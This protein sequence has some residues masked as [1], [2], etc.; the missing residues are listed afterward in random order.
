M[1]GEAKKLETPSH[2]GRRHYQAKEL[3]RSQMLDDSGLSGRTW[4]HVGNS[5]ATAA[6]TTPSREVGKRAQALSLPLVLQFAI[7]PP[8]WPP[9]K[10][11]NKGA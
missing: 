8:H 4:S 11:G 6:N 10:P 5:A 9:S 3:G 7:M 2:T 1:S